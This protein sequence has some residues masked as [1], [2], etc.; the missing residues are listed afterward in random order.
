MKAQ[1]FNPFGVFLGKTN[2]KPEVLEKNDYGKTVLARHVLS[3]GECTR[4][5]LTDQFDYIKLAPLDFKVTRRET[6]VSKKR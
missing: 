4:L 2:V 3:Q 1:V 6:S 5:K